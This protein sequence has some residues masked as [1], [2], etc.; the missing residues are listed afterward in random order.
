MWSVEKGTKE[1]ERIGHGRKI[2]MVMGKSSRMC[3]SKNATVR[4]FT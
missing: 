4:T 1:E 2:K 3:S